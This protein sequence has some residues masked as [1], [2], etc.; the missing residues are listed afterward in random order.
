MRPVIQLGGFQQRFGRDTPRVKARAA[1]R[2]FAVR[3]LPLVDAGDGELVLAGANR[4]RIAG[5][6]AADD[7]DVERRLKPN[8]PL[9]NLKHQPC[10][11]FQA[12]FDSD[13]ELDR[14]TAVDDAVV[15]GQRDVHHRAH[16]DL[17]VHHHRAILDLV[18]P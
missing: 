16:D 13:Q 9:L 4:G 6:T 8:G 7:D 12:L 17:A 18:H 1:E 10:R 3:V 14:F 11:V 5:G 2:I 15:V